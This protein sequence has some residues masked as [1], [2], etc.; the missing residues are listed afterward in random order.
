MENSPEYIAVYYGVL[1]A[2]AVAV[3]LNNATKSRDIV[4]WLNHSEARWLFAD[5]Q[6][7]ELPVIGERIDLGLHLIVNGKPRKPIPNLRQTPWVQVAENDSAQCDLSHL[8]RDERP[9]AII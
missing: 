1:A 5:G 7:A 4:N 3:G 6:H 8:D 2:G 9:A